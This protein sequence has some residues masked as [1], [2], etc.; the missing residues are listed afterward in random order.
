LGVRGRPAE[1]RSASRHGGRAHG[2][3]FARSS[4]SRAIVR[5]ARHSMAR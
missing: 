3:G 4:V 5:L 2:L 1:V